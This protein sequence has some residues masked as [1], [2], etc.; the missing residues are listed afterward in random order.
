MTEYRLFPDVEVPYVSTYDFHRNRPRAAHLEQP[1]HRPRLLAAANYVH[2]ATENSPRTVVDLGCGDGGLLSLVQALPGV[3]KAWGYDW[4]PSN[5][6][7]WNQR[8]VIAETV[9]VFGVDRDRIDLGFGSVVVTTEVLEH[10]ADPHGAV[11][12]L[13]H[14]DRVSYLVASSPWAESPMMHDECHAWAWDL[15]GYADLLRQGGFTV[16][17]HEPVGL[18]QVATAVRT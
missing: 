18:F 2:L 5:E 7:G 9:D 12:W 16:T 1:G 13:G 15:A 17:R 6:D 8:G 10:L 14:D 3:T 4:Q 11:K